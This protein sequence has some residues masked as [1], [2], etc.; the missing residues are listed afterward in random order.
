VH[1]N[2]KSTNGNFSIALNGTVEIM[3]AKREVYSVLNGLIAA[4]KFPDASRSHL[5]NIDPLILPNSR[6]ITD[7]SLPS[8][9]KGADSCTLTV[10]VNI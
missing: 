3:D 9:L 5:F 7:I 1:I 6:S 4:V 10:F 2:S 8:H